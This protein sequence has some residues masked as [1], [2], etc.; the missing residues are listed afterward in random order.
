LS[1]ESGWMME[2]SGSTNWALR[3]EVPVSP[4]RT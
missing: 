1:R 4:M 2:L 3:G